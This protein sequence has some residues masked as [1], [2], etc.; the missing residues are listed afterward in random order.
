[1]QLK[2]IGFTAMTAALMLAAPLFTATPAK[3]ET[4]FSF[5][6]GVAPGYR[7]YAPPPVYYRPPYPGP[8]YYWTDGYYDPYGAWIGGYWAPRAYVAPYYGGRFYNGYRGDYY[9]DR[10]YDRRDYRGRGNAY[11]RRR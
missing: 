1:M 11:G 9:R 5:G 6:I 7:Y 3:A 4:H 8:G 2:K 10:H